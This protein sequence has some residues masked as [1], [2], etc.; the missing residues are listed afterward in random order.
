MSNMLA[1]YFTNPESNCSWSVLYVVIISFFI[2]VGVTIGFWSLVYLI[3]KKHT[4]VKE[5]IRRNMP[6][7]RRKRKTRSTKRNGPTTNKFKATY[8][9]LDNNDRDDDSESKSS[10]LQNGKRSNNTSDFELLGGRLQNGLDVTVKR[11]YSS[12][13]LSSS[14]DVTI[15]DS[16]SAR[17]SKAANKDRSRRSSAGSNNALVKP[18][19]T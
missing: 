17:R 13:D 3:T 10:I 6:G 4:R 5:A 7:Q 15:F 11:G 1:E 14:D 12:S 19:R 16:T 2:L 9:L 18:L 8:T